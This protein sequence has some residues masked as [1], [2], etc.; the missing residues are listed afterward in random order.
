M[1]VS[2]VLI[3]VVVVIVVIV[4]VVVVILIIRHA[5]SHAVVSNTGRSA[6]MKKA[7]QAP[8]AAK[9]KAVKV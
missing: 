8:A 6:G 5:A 9:T 4:I 3:V 7:K 1:C 2:V